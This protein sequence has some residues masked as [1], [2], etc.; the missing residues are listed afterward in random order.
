MQRS[1]DQDR[2]ALSGENSPSHKHC[3]HRSSLRAALSYAD[4]LP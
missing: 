1:V 2:K 4:Q 3:A